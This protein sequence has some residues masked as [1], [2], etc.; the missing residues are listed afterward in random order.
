[1]RLG[2]GPGLILPSGGYWLKEVTNRSSAA[3]RLVAAVTADLD[4]VGL[5]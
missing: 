3:E 5:W 1:M 4:A 2:L